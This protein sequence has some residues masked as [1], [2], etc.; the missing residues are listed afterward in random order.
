MFISSSATAVNGSGL[1]SRRRHRDRMVGSKASS[2]VVR[3][4]MS[5]WGGGFFE[6]LQEGV[7]RLFA[8][9]L[10]AVEDKDP[11]AAFVRLQVG[12]ALYLSDVPNTDLPPRRPS[13]FSLTD[14]NHEYVGVQ[15]GGYTTALRAITAGGYIRAEA[16]DCLGQVD[17]KGPFAHLRR[18]HEEVGMGQAAFLEAG[19]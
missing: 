13:I 4:T 17:G 1:I 16:V 2:A 11:A 10:G 12:L 18:T 19:F 14:S 7:G 6:G 9:V 5:T 3:R 15:A 8:H